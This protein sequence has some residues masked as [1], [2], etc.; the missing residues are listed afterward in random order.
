MCFKGAPPPSHTPRPRLPTTSGS[1]GAV[2]LAAA[3]SSDGRYAA[4]RAGASDLVCRGRVG[5]LLG[6]IGAA[7]AGARSRPTRPLP[8]AAPRPGLRRGRPG[9][10]AHR[11]PGHLQGRG[12][13]GRAPGHHVRALAPPAARLQ[14]PDRWSPDRP[15]RGHRVRQR[16]G[17]AGPA[18]PGSARRGPTAA[19]RADAPHA[20]LVQR[21]AVRPERHHGRPE[22]ALHDDRPD[23][24]GH[25]GPRDGRA[26]G[27][28]PRGA[29]RR[30]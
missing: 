23:P 25:P 2:R 13:A 22:P 12:F 26:L 17:A 9:V 27:A 21:R 1:G 8:G 24:H 30:R 7:S 18:P 10:A 28:A 3:L 15:G 6:G 20:Q 4:A 29:A 19:Q 16:L 14:R 5:V 11:R